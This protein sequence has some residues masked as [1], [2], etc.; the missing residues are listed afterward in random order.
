MGRLSLRRTLKGGIIAVIVGLAWNLYAG[1]S[2]LNTVVIVN[3]NSPNSVEL[4]NYYTERRQVPPENVLRVNWTGGNISWTA[5]EFQP[6]LLDPLLAMLAARGLTS[7][8]DYVVLSMDFPFQ[9]YNGT[10]INSTTAALFYGLKT[11]SGPEWQGIT[12]SYYASEKIFRQAKPASAPG[13][14]FLTVMLTAGSLAQAKALVDRGVDGDATFPGA[15]VVLAKSS[16]TLRN[17]RYRL[18]DHAIFNVQLSPAVNYSIARVTADLP[19]TSPALLGLQTGLPYFNLPNNSFVPGAMA[20][21]LTSFGGVISGGGQTTLLEFIHAGASGS[22][23]TVTEP[24]PVPDKFPNPQ[25]YFYQSRGFNIAECYYQSLGV[26]YQGLIVAEPLCAPFATPG[27]GSW[28]GITANAIISGTRQFTVNFSAADALHP[29]QQVDL[30]VD[31]KFNRTL[32][33]LPPRSGNVVNLNIN[34]RPM[35][36]VI[37]ANATIGSLASDL[38]A[39]INQAANLNATKVMA[40]V[41]GDRLELR[42]TS[43]ARP[44]A[45]PGFCVS[46]NTPPGTPT[47]P[48]STNSPPIAG[49]SAG[50]ASALTTFVTP[51]NEFFPAA[52]PA[53]GVRSYTVN[54]TMQPG[55]W[56]RLTVTRTNGTQINVGIT[57][58]S[59]S[60]TPL[61]LA[62]NL[63]RAINLT[64][65]LQGADGLVAEDLSPWFSGGA[66]FNLRARTPGFAPAGIKVQLASNGLALN[67]GGT[68]TL[69][70][71]LADLQPRNH[72]YV[73][74]GATNLN[75]TFALNT[76]TLSDGYHELT[77]V[78]YEGSHVQ[79]QTRVTMPVRVQNTALS[80]TL[81]LVNFPDPSPVAD[82]YQIQVIANTNNVSAIRLYSTGGLLGTVN[83]QS[84]ATFNVNGTSL[85]IGRHPFYAV[86]ETT[87]GLQYR[88]ET[89]R[90]RL[91]ATP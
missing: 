82:T 57:N 48:T 62:S 14:S 41:R 35:G 83:N 39:V 17:I 46:S 63:V 30:F 64:T 8:I 70:E 59:V 85:G 76:A 36:L 45:P 16:D 38:G 40:L 7:Q 72:L 31:G 43:G 21:S 71:N 20:D 89:Q 23:G 6:V 32:T 73:T 84:T 24:Q 13:P 3:Q 11:D 69:T 60:A 49:T 44:F 37:P 78:A 67:P 61:T 77:A 91:V 42:S 51:G 65:A 34:Q 28:N 66:G 58:Q 88:T 22:Y 47:F 4:G 74:A 29:L 26:P 2:G 9:T 18:F 12:N 1:G 27:T 56:L 79:T 5:A 52:S 90:V 19:P 10:V 87:G 75:V 53:F 54:G 80:A 50:S 86:V 15:T 33:N 81:T 55:T 25:N 68:N